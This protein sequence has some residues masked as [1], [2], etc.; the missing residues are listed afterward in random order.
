MHIKRKIAIATLL[1]AG[2][3]MLTFIYDTYGWY[4]VAGILG[5]IALSIGMLSL[6]GGD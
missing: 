5:V 4:G 1:F 6:E 3:A 2:M